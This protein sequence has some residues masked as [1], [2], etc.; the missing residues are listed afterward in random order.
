MAD[1]VYFNV[2]QFKA[3]LA[4]GGARPNQF[5]VQLTFPATVALGALAI[6]SSPF[7][8]TAASMPGSHIGQATVKYRGR[9]VP[10][11]GDRYFDAWTI[12]ILNDN[13]FTIRNAIEDW[14]NQIND[15]QN[16]SGELSP[17]KY[18]ADMLVTQLNRNNQPLKTYQ[19]RGAWPVDLSDSQLDFTANDQISQSSV[20]FRYQDFKTTFTPL[21]GIISGG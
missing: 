19:I 9:D 16:A 3:Q 6:Q 10:L 7:L 14:M 18:Q 5:F 15:L 21:A 2:D 12:N 4:G 20:T 11:A 17:A 13:N 8:V 1:T